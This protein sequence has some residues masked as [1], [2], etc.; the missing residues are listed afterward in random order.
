M[1]G[2]VRYTPLYLKRITN[3]DL[4]YGAG[5]SAQC[6]VAAGMGGQLGREWI[7]VCECVHAKSVQ[8]GPAPGNAMD[9]SLPGSPVHG[10]SRRE[11]WSGL[12][13]LPPRDLTDPGIEPASLMSTCISMWVLYH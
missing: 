1:F 11:Y 5:N 3:K 12:P 2:K 10:F 7:L 13:C 6:Y 8:L 4:L 9:H